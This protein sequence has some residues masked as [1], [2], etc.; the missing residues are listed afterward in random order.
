MKG[1]L[2]F[3]NDPKKGLAEKIAPAVARFYERLG[4]EALTVLV[5]SGQAA[6]CEQVNGIRVVECDNIMPGYI[7]ITDSSVEG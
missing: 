1:L 2:W 7:W 3:D 4:R 5:A 6:A